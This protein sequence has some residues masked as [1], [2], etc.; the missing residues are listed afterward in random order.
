MNRDL[1]RVWQEAVSVYL[2]ILRHISGRNEEGHRE[3][4][5]G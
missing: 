5:W 2:K 3:H 1:G 4:Q